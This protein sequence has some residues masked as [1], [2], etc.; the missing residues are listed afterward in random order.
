MEFRTLVD[1][2]DPERYAMP[3]EVEI[4]RV[5]LSLLHNAPVLT[6]HAAERHTL[7]CR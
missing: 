5:L 1:T 7:A 3:T 4:V 6:I 2:S